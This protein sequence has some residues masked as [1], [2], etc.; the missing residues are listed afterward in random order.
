M[1]VPAENVGDSEGVSI[2]IGAP[3][4]TTEEAQ[5]YSRQI[6][7]RNL[8]G[9]DEAEGSILGEMKSNSAR[10]IAAL[11]Q[12]Q[13]SIAQ[14]QYNPG[15]RRDAVA[16]ALLAPTRSGSSSE[17]WSN[18]FAAN[19]GETL[20]QQS[21]DME[22]LKSILDMQQKIASAPDAIT[23]ARMDLQKLHETQETPLTKEAL[24]TLGRS[25]VPGAGSLSSFDKIAIGE[26]Y[27]A[28]TPQHIARVRDLVAQDLRNKRATAGTDQ[29]D[30]HEPDHSDDAYKY[31]VP[32]DAPYPWLN[33]SSKER[34]QMMQTERTGAEKTLSTQDSAVQQAQQVQRD[35]DRFGFLN[36]RTATSSLQGVPGIQQITGMGQDAKEMDKISARLGPMMRQPGMGR[37]TNLDLQTF[38]ASTVGRD[39]PKAVN[40]S[41]RTAMGTAINNQLDYTRYLHDYFAVHRTLQ[42]AEEKWFQYLEA[43]PI[44]DP[45]AT[46][47]SFATNK[48]RLNYKDYFRSLHP[49]GVDVGPSQF[50]DVTDADRQDPTFA[51]MSDEEIHNSKVPAHARG[52]P[53]RGYAGGGKVKEDDDYKADLEDLMRSLEQGATFQ[54]GDEL[55]AAARPGP[56]SENVQNERGQQE[57]FG[58]SHPWSNTGLELAGGAASSVAAAKLAQMALRGAK[59]KAGA[60]GAV[61]NLASR[62]TPKNLY[63]KAAG[64]G[65][66]AGAISGAGSA[67]DVE[68]VPGMAAEQATI[69]GVAG[70]LG[71]LVTK[72]GVNGAM[73]L[74]DKLRGQQVPGGAQRVIAALNSDKTTT[75]EIA[76]RLRATGRQGVPSTMANVGGPNIQGL[77]Q[78]VASKQSPGVDNFIANAR[79]Q[80]QTSNPRVTDLVN[81]A[82]KPDD[83]AQ[84]MTELTTNL[85]Q[86]AKPLYE[87]AYA[88]YPK[89]KSDT[90]FDILGNKY[91]KKAAKQAYDYMQADGV[92]I[93]QKDVTG[94]VRK[95]SLQYL[96]YVKRGLDDQITQARNAG[97]TNLAR[98]L[99]GMKTRLVGELDNFTTDPKTGDSLYKAARQQYAGDLEVRDALKTGREDLFGPNGLTPAEIKAK[100]ANMSWAEKDALRT[101]AAESLFQQIGNTPVTTNVAG[102]LTQVPNMQEKLAAMFD[103]PGEYQQFMDALK[104]EM[105]NFT[106]A[107]TLLSTQARSKA[108]SSAASLDPDG[109]AGEA[110]YEAAIAGMH[111]LWAGARAAKWVG[112]KLMPNTTAG[113]AAELLN[114]QNNPA[115]RTSLD[116]LKNQ[117]AQLAARQN[118]GDSSALAA[119]G[120]TG[121]ALAP[122]PWGNTEPSQ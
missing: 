83:Y 59:G 92:P 108:A 63:L 42:G 13:Q 94:A 8:A 56:Y 122:D 31:G 12:A 85:Y 37:M 55:N 19:H 36:N 61:A 34:K 93:G 115:G 101:G 95:P 14:A 109:S 62:L 99:N 35:L 67:Q 64:A 74:I 1:S 98:I 30:Y 78:G 88:A 43:N 72:Y 111:P 47:G 117:A 46:P 9:N 54:W 91:G 60:L 107:K 20:A 89:V 70:P 41:I 97:N 21:F 17:G 110:A 82:L 11:R 121:P 51:G 3:Q 16:S 57:R 77:A 7:D 103:K 120:A 45:K 52:G 75:D 76:N 2:N 118:T 40:D 4:T 119:A 96:D 32:D 86:N 114:I 50:S 68:S 28:G 84:K 26:G 116:M 90:I 79:Q 112:N 66:G 58:G 25:I 15:L 38:M 87:Q 49:K 106:Q 5:K 33:A 65:A 48:G 69:G 23:Q 105:N 27:P 100:V 102:K 73:A 24:T 39:K 104:Q 81:K 29:Q 71:A 53:I 18:A 10:A 80:F 6:L 22:R 44:F 113:Q